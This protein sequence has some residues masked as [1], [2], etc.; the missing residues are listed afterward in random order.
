LDGFISAFEQFEFSVWTVWVQRLNS[1][2][3]A[4]EQFEFSVSTVWVQRFNSFISAFERFYF[5][6]STVLFQRLKCFSSAFQRF[7]FRVWTVWPKHSNSLPKHPN[8]KSKQSTNGLWMLFQ[9]TRF[10]LKVF[11]C[12]VTYMYIMITLMV[13]LFHYHHHMVICHYRG[14]KPKSLSLGN[15]LSPDKF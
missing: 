8:G 3:S 13:T 12:V 10:W 2:S 7:D 1:L 15:T 11:P 6:V 4:F 9:T 5:R 14:S